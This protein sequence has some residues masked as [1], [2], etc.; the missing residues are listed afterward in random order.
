MAI[1]GILNKIFFDVKP[2]FVRMSENAEIACE[3]GTKPALYKHSEW[4]II[5]S[6][7]KKKD[8]YILGAVSAQSCA[9]VFSRCV[10]LCRDMVG[11]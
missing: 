8:A 7:E 11:S 9:I 4:C 1:I 3:E 2:L 10:V 6:N 5:I